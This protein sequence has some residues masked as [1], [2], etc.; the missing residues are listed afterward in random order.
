MLRRHKDDTKTG[1]DREIEL[2]GR[3]LEVLKRQLAL[4]EAYARGGK[5]DRHFVFFQHTGAP[6]AD[7]QYAYGRWVYVAE[8]AGAGGT[9]PR[10]R[11]VRRRRISL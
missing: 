7:L 10:G 1:E 9:T 3:A 2:C 4:R 6:L 8:Q 5:I 11:K